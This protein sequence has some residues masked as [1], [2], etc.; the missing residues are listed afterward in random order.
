MSGI[1]A[2]GASL[3]AIARDADGRRAVLALANGTQ[4]AYAFDAA[5]QLTA[6]AHANSGGAFATRDYD[7]NAIGLRTNMLSGIA[8]VGTVLDEYAHDPLDQLV[9]AQY[10]VGGG[11]PMRDV[12]YSFDGVGNRLAVDDNGA[13]TP[14]VANDLNQYTSVG[15][16]G[17]TYDANGNLA[18][19]PGFTL[20]YDAQNRLIQAT[21]ATGS[22]TFAYDGRNRCVKRTTLT[23]DGGSSTWFVWGHA[24]SGEWGLLEERDSSGDVVARYVH[25]DRIDEILR[26]EGP[27]GT[28]FYHHDALGSTIALT[29]AS[30]ALVEQYRFDVFGLPTVLD[31]SGAPSSLDPRTSSFGNRFLFTGREWLSDL[32]LYD[33]RHRVY[34]PLLGRWLQPDPIGFAAGDLNLYRYGRNSDSSFLDPFGLAPPSL[35]QFAHPLNWTDGLPDIPA[36]AFEALRQNLI[37]LQARAY[38]ERKRAATKG[39]LPREYAFDLVHPVSGPMS[40]RKRFSAN[41]HDSQP[42]TTTLGAVVTPGAAGGVI[43]VSQH[44]GIVIRVHSHNFS[45]EFSRLDKSLAG[46]VVQGILTPSGS[47]RVWNPKQPNRTTST[48]SYGFE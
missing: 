34:S 12:Q 32:A 40:Q 45:E 48:K 5:S 17:L 43:T 14:Y 20:T 3:A 13:V 42:A 24:Q 4:T 22:V 23:L 28:V 9:R 21:A 30:G 36:E 37:L 44:P 11:T 41:W 1:S 39:E 10:D 19:G 16:I 47:F 18:A 31:A 2:G 46:T 27:E 25:G 7:Y 26:R 33:Y 8:G 38:E 6:L 15:G 29:D 35:Q